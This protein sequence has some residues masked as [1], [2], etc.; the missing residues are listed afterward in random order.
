MSVVFPILCFGVQLNIT[1][2]AHAVNLYFGTLKIRSD[3]AVPFADVE[4]AH[5]PVACGLSLMPEQSGHP[6]ALNLN[7]V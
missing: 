2:H 4:N 7:L 1:S 3:A 5:M 6:K